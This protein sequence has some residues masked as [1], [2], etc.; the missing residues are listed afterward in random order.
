MFAQLPVVENVIVQRFMAVGFLAAAVMLAVILDRVHALGDRTGAAWSARVAV[1]AV[2]LVPMAVTFGARLPFAMR[3]RDSCLAGTPRWH[4]PCPRAGAAVV[5]GALL[6]DPVGHGLAGGQ[7]HALQ[8]G[9][10]RGPPGGASAGRRGR[11]RV[12]AC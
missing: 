12:P 4:R 1:A 10:R 9:R 8:P 5:S 7:P 3:P 6:R 2:A 11:G